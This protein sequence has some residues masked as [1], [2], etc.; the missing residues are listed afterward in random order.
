V[1]TLPAASAA[2]AVELFG[3]TTQGLFGFG[4]NLVAA[5]LL[6]LIDPK[7]APSPI[8]LAGIASSALIGF[9]NRSSADRTAVGWALAGRVPG[10]ALVVLILAIVAGQY[11]RPLVGAVV[12][13]SAGVVAARRTLKRTRPALVGVGVVSGV[14]SPIAGLGGAPLGLM[15]HDLPGRVLRSTLAIFSLAGALLAA[16]ALALAGQVSS[17]SLGL[18]AV[19]LP[20]VA[21]GF[22]LSGLLV[23]FA[24]RWK[25]MKWAVLALA[26]IGAVAAIVKGL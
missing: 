21:G 19:L 11:L 20:G 5:P 16:A 10:T 6:V 25:S 1:L 8:V 7:F 17:A 4:I 22:V 12:L 2:A 23:P 18:T 26:T 24:D 3:A 9:R 13:C 15:C 14:M